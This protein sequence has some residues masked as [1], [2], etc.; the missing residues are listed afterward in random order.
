M[1]LL[2]RNFEVLKHFSILV[3]EKPGLKNIQKEAKVYLGFQIS[4]NMGLL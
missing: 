3:T 1:L 4:Q 2:Y